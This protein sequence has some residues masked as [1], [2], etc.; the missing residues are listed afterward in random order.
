MTSVGKDGTVEFW[1]Y[2]K[3]VSAVKVVGDFTGGR[4]QDLEMW[5][6]HSAPTAAAKMVA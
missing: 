1:F 5:R 2:R 6:L 4:G 3:G